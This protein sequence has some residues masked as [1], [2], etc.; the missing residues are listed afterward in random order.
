MFIF[1]YIHVRAVDEILEVFEPL[2][3]GLLGGDRLYSMEDKGGFT[4]QHFYL[5]LLDRSSQL[6]QRIIDLYFILLFY[7][8]LFTVVVFDDKKMN[9]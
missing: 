6:G 2:F 5:S 1:S 3:Y 4:K 9:Q 8:Y 7:S